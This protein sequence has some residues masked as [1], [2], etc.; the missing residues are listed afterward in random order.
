M[1]IL[2]TV[3]SEGMSNTQLGDYYNVVLKKNNEIK[4]N[5]NVKHWSKDEKEG[6]YGIV[7][8]D[9][10]NELIM[11]LYEGSEYYIMTDSGKTFEK[12]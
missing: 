8:F 4:F 2:R 3:D 9:Y 7:L 5:E 11:P 6:L 12:L 10:D 1:F